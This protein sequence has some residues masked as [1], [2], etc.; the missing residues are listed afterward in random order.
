MA[1][2][3]R[4]KS[5]D[6]LLELVVD[7]A[8]DGDW[9]VGLEGFAWHT[10]GDLLADQCSSPP[11]L[12]VRSAVRAFVDDIISSR[13]RY[14]IVISR[15]GGKIRDAWIDDD[16]SCDHTKYAQPGETVEKRFWDGRPAAG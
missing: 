14:V 3:E 11:E 15:V 4:H 8:D 7:R 2:V 5:P 1:I 13:S 9:M 12:A 6:G 10:H 16:P